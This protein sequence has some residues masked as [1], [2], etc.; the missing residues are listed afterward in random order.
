MIIHYLVKISF[1]GTYL[2]VPMSA[3]NK[4]VKP[5]ASSLI[6]HIKQATS[7][8]NEDGQDF[9]PGKTPPFLR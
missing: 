5:L 6:T 1:S 2:F 7:S 3:E 4:Q 9:V 8:M